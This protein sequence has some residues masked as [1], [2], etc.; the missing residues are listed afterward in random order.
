MDTELWTIKDVGAYLDENDFKQYRKLFCEE[1]KIDGRV[2]LSLTEND[3]KQAPLQIL[4]FGDLRRLCFLIENLRE[5]KRNRDQKTSD[6]PFK[7]TYSTFNNYIQS[8]QSS[9]RSGLSSPSGGISITDS[10]DDSFQIRKKLKLDRRKFALSVLYIF[11]SH[12]FSGFAVTYAQ[13]HLPDKKKYPPLPDIILDNLPFIPWAYRVTEGAIF[14]LIIIGLIML[15]FHK[16]RFLVI[17]R[18]MIIA[19]TIYLLR[20]FCV[21]S[22]AIPMPQKEYNCNRIEVKDGWER[23]SRVVRFYAAI[24][25]KSNGIKTCGDYVFSGHTVIMTLLVL[26]INEYTPRSMICLHTLNW[27]VGI[28]GVFFILLGHGHYTLDILLAFFISSKLF[29]YHHTIAINM[30]L[31]SRD[32]HRMKKCFPVLYYFEQD[33]DGHIP[34]EYE[35][36]LPKVKKVESFYSDVKFSFGSYFSSKSKQDV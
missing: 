16:Y 20:S 5:E 30:S 14:F 34:N 4:P 25:L 29:S 13:E 7:Q 8:E 17:Q 2:F 1:N 31:I 21:M 26:S 28:F 3:L 6:S 24:G 18:I 9:T 27:I 35:W 12:F 19:A 10:D 33:T 15:F 11:C 22:T 36:P 32:T 23:L